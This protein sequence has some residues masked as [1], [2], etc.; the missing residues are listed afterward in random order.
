MR[1]GRWVL[2]VLVLSPL[3]IAR[4]QQQQQQ[5]ASQQPAQQEDS[6]AGAAR[7]AR[8]QKKDQAKSKKV[9]DND[10]LPATQGGVNVV[11]Q[12]ESGSEAS[13]AGTAEPHASPAGGN[14][15]GGAGTTD[16]ASNAAKSKAASSAELSAAKEQLQS[17]KTDLD[18]LQRTA[19]LDQQVYYSNPDHSSDKE[20]AAKLKDEQN[21]IEAKQQEV[22]DAQ[23]K[24]DELQSKLNS[25]SDNK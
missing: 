14:Q 23:K 12:T 7:R 24:V 13:P 22:A 11:G 10:N 20:G 8:D 3:G 1:V 18:I 2:L 5:Q 16:S 17:L 15:G 19:T 4:A 6:L 9:Y 21:E 25:G